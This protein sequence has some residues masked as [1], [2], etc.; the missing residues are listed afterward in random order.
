MGAC[1]QDKTEAANH[2]DLLCFRYVLVLRCFLLPGPY[3]VLEAALNV[4]LLVI[5]YCL[6]A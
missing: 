2:D 4:L 5:G 1:F 3:R 6:A